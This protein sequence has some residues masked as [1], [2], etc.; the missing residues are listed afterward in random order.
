MI[1]PD[2]PFPQL[3]TERLKLRCLTPADAVELF[4]IHSDHETMQWFG[5][6]PMTHLEQAQKLIQ[7]FAEWRTQA[8]PG[9]RW[10]LERLADGRLIGTCGLFKWQRDWRKCMLG[11]ELSRAAVGQGYMEEALRAVLPWGMREMG[12]NRI[13]AQ[14]HPD[15]LPSIRLAER[16]HFVAEGTLREAGYWGGRYHDMLQYGL[17]QRD[18]TS[19]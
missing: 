15:N 9:T 14:I 6:D 12:L 3:Q 10:G 17:L 16:L 11:Y 2:S 19:T 18:Y 5:V 7:T 13:E 1:E 4:A 8:N